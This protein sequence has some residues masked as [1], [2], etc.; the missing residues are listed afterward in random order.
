MVIAGFPTKTADYMASGRPILVFGPEY[1]SL[2]RY[3]RQYGFA[4]VVTEP[5]DD[6]LAKGIKDIVNSSTRRAEL[7]SRAFSV[8]STNHDIFKQR[9]EFQRL[10]AELALN[11][12]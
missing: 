3:A 6:A 4:E 9:R 11:Q 10:V 12:G 8:L 7:V 1:S 2:V 5:G